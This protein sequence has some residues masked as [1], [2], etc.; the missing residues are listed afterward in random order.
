M[1]DKIKDHF[2]YRTFFSENIPADARLFNVVLMFCLVGSL[3]GWLS[4][5]LQASSSISVLSTSLLPVTIFLF[6]FWINKS[7]RYKLGG[8]LMCFLLCDIVFPFIFFSSGGIRSGMLAY[9]LLGI[10][11]LSVLLHGKGYVLMLSLYLLISTG[12]FWMAYE[13]PQ[14][15]TPIASE[16]LICI[17]IATSFIFSS[18][19]ISLVIRYQHYEQVKAQKT[20]ENEWQRAE[21]ASR[22]KSDFL[23]NMSHEIRTPIN[24]IIGMITIA[25]TASDPQKK[26]DCL[27]KINDASL[28]LLGVINDILDM[29]KIEANKLDLSLS[30]FDSKELFQELVSIIRFQTDAKQ[31][32][33]TLR[34]DETIPRLWISDRQRLAQAIMNLL[35]NAIKFTPKHGSI[36]LDVR[37]LEKIDNFYTIQIEVTDTGIGILPEQQPNLFHSFQQA[38][39]SISRKFGGT[40]LGLSISQH[41]IEM[42]GGK[43][44]VESE[45]GKGSTF[46]FSIQVE[47]GKGAHAVGA[48][49]GA[50][51]DPYDTNGFEGYH[52]LLAEDVEINREIV[53]SLLEPTALTFDCA[54]NG[55]QALQLYAAAAERYDFIF[56]DIQMPEMDGY[57]A[58]RRIR[59]LDLECAKQVPIIAMTANVFREDID[60]CLAAGMNGHLGK[61]LAYDKMLAVLRQYLPPKG[62]NVPK[63]PD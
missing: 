24:A 19:L 43:I 57:E 56:M 2:F 33:F 59:A 50:D 54:E 14:W 26:D 20:A 21:N 30:E 13:H 53:L 55:V 52:I 40:G 62:E 46:A 51:N 27:N 17:D 5:L 61:P 15:V 28:H 1:L 49:R 31:Q 44:R 63:R 3:A 41:I 47:R 7:R 34:L 37:L 9:L 39:S 4:T 8:L 45:F 10:V 12:C 22:S 35:S 60:K 42:L 11:L 6:L 58:T 16:F 23:S 29:S 25:K 48:F 38:D 36:R 32:H 18:L